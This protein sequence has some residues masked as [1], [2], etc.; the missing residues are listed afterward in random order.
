MNNII[1]ADNQDITKLGWM[2]LIGQLAESKKLNEVSEK[3]DLINL[4]L[5]DSDALVILDYTLFDFES[6]NELI[7]LQ[8]R[9]PDTSWLLFSEE[10]SDDFSVICS[11]IRIRSACF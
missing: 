11:I 10:L 3:K 8:T 2:Y 1:L 9:F 6:I 5:S 4:L 7:I